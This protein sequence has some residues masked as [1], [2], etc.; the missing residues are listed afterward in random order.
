MNSYKMIQITNNN[1]GAVAADGYMPFGAVTRKIANGQSCPTPF[2]VTTSGADII[3]LTE[4]GYYRV[5]YNASVIAG[6]A[7][8]VSLTLVAGGNE[9]YTASATAASGDTVNLTLPYEV[10]VFTNCDSVPTNCP[11][12]VQIELGDVAITGGTA[13]IIIEKVY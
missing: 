1:V 13:N 9:V 4:P 3:E 8:I 2:Y 5:T 10:R 6:T 11:L 7:G 12:A